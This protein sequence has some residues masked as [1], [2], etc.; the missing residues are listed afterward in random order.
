VSGQVWALAGGSAA[1]FFVGADNPVAFRVGIDGWLYYLSNS[2]GTVIRLR[3]PGMSPPGNPTVPRQ[4]TARPIP[5]T[6]RPPPDPLCNPARPIVVPT[7][8][9]T[10]GQQPMDP[11]M[12][13]SR[14][15][16][17]SNRVR[18]MRNGNWG[19]VGLDAS[20]GNRTRNSG[21]SLVIGKEWFITGYGT[22]ALST[23]QLTLNK[24]CFRMTSWVGVDQETRRFYGNDSTLG[25]GEFVLRN[26]D[27]ATRPAIWNSSL[28]VRR[29]LTGGAS[30]LFVDRRNLQGITRLQL[31]AGVPRRFAVTPP[32]VWRA[33]HLDWAETKLYC[34][35]RAPY[36][37]RITLI[38]P[39]PG[40]AVLPNSNVTFSARATFWDGRTVIPASGYNWDINLIHCQGA[41]CHQHNPYQFKGVTSGQFL[42]FPHDDTTAQYYY[43]S[44][45]LRVTDRCGNYDIIRRSVT[46]LGFQEM[47]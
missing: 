33:A 19:P 42:A 29:R 41:L 1:T 24:C 16:W 40:A 13:V 11:I 36:A 39:A 21:R 47:A 37:P 5:T 35:P 28:Q 22:H 34:G 2:G 17:P 3:I 25:E 15:G 38:S 6:T 9:V 7:C 10:T 26:V 31:E 20:V 43:W 12:W 45:Q 4:T 18:F 23:I 44:V 8:A 32:K 14:E 27:M 46:M 30:P